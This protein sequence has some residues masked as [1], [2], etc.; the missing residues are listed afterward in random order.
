MAASIDCFLFLQNKRPC[1]QL[2]ASTAVQQHTAA[3][4]M[5]AFD[6]LLG[7]FYHNELAAVK[8]DF[9]YGAWGLQKRG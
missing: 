2:T 7:R 6:G 1:E 8:A 3:T 9:L 4:Q 5:A